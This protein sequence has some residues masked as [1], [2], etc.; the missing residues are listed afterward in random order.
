M[1]ARVK[2]ADLPKSSM[3]WDLVGEDDFLDCYAV[4]C[5]LSPRDAAGVA[6]TFPAWVKALLVARNVLVR[7]FGLKS[8]SGGGDRVNI[9]PV[10]SENADEVVMGFDDR[11]L[12]FRSAMRVENGQAYGATWVH[13]RNWLGRF[14]LIVVMP[15]HIVI[16]RSAMARVG[17]A[18]RRDLVHS[19]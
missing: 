17:R 9:F 15:F 5:T 19:G 2:R 7:P 14:Y 11:H 12:D 18:S 6:F 10:T 3:L 4:R 8:G 13:R 16:M 1:G